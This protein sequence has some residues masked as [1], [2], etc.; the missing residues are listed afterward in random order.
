MCLLHFVHPSVT[1]CVSEDGREDQPQSIVFVSPDGSEAGPFVETVCVPV[2]GA[3]Y[4]P[5]LWRYRLVDRNK[6][7]RYVRLLLGPSQRQTEPYAG[8]VELTEVEVCGE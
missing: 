7:A 4:S 8:V 1:I 2:E 3:V 6:R 5:N